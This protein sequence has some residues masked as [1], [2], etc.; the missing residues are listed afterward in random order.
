MCLNASQKHVNREVEF[1]TMTHFKL[2]LRHPDGV[3]PAGHFLATTRR[4]GN[5]IP[6]GVGQKPTPKVTAHFSSNRGFQTQVAPARHGVWYQDGSNR[7]K[8]TAGQSGRTPNSGHNRKG[9]FTC[10]TV[11]RVVALSKM[12]TKQKHNKNLLQ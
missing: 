3:V 10:T 1:K 8:Y 11:A 12:G 6:I 9:T 7:H 4:S 5:A 2:K